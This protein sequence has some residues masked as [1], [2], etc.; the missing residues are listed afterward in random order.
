M[1]PIFGLIP[2]SSK[3][4]PAED[5]LLVFLTVSEAASKRAWSSILPAV[6]AVLAAAFRA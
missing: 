4:L 1:K 3:D 6:L 2:I 5:M